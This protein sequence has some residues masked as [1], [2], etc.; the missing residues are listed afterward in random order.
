LDTSL[1]LL[2]HVSTMTLEN[3]K[4][5]LGGHDEIPPKERDADFLG[6]HHRTS[7]V[8]PEV[9]MYLPARNVISLSTKTSILS[10]THL[11]SGVDQGCPLELRHESPEKV[12]IELSLPDFHL[13]VFKFQRKII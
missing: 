8:A 12:G 2:Q 13:N 1:T 6:D 10:R 5:K 7:Q 4:L 11:L 3:E 9:V